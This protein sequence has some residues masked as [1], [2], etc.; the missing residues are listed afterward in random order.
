VTFATTESAPPNTAVRRSRWPLHG[1]AAGLL[2]TVATLV[3]DVHVAASDAVSQS[4]P[5]LIEAINR[6]AAH[7]SIV[8]GY[9]CV[10]FLL[11]FAASWRLHAE[12]RATHSAATRVVPAGIVAAAGA[13]TL[14]YGWKGALAIYLPGGTDAGGFDRSGLYIYYILNDFGSFIGW[15]GVTIAAGAIAW[16]AL[17]ERTISRWIGIVSLLPVLGTTAAVTL[18][19][20]PGAP[21]I[22]SAAW[23]LI[24]SLGLAL[25]R[26]AISR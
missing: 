16:M 19:G 11:V 18:T 13:L 22:F 8:A 1:V 17:R 6:P 4:D 10:A 23:L 26:S 25:G 7:L 20:L 3:G 9:L 5:G 15:L 2:G 14:G 12:P 21:G 24:A